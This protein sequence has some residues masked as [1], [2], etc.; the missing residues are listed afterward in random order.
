MWG[1]CEVYFKK[2]VIIILSKRNR[3]DSIFMSDL[4]T[5][6]AIEKNVHLDNS[7]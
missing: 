1:K 4:F 6:I 3:I 7:N 2:S 5:Y